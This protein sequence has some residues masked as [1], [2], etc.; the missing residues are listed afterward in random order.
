MFPNPQDALPIPRDPNLE[1]YRKLAKELLRAAKS[2]DPEAIRT[3]STNWVKR[4]VERS[5]IEI[6][7]QLPVRTDHWIRE[8]SNF[9]QAKLLQDSKLSDAQF[10][11][12]RSHGF[13]NW[14]KFVKHLQDAN[15]A[16]SPE[17]QFEAAADAII[18]GDIATLRRLLRDHPRLVHRRSTRE[19][20]ATLLHYVSANGVEG[21]RQKTPKN[22]VEI[23]ELLLGAGADIN[24]GARVY[25]GNCTALGLAAT[26]VHPQQAGV[27]RPLMQLLLD[28][29][30][31][32]D[33][34]GLAG[35]GH[36]LMLA[37]L[38]NGQP[39]AARFLAEHGAPLDLETAAVV[40]KL[41]VVKQ[42]FE[43]DGNL[44]PPATRRELQNGF[45]WACMYGSEDVAIFLLDLGAD[46]QD[47]S[48]TGAT[49][50]HWAAGAG[51]LNLIKLFIRR[52]AL[53]EVVNRW[54]GTVLEHA[55]HG[56]EHGPASVNFA[57]TFETL[58]EAGA[59]IQG[60]WL[61]W[62]EKLKGR[63]AEEKAQ[64]AE[65]FRRYGATA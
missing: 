47:P 6:P 22:I 33:Q 45:L 37:C 63:S 24:A 29:G 36:S 40:G 19:H 62:L 18:S 59:K 28:H 15:H 34:P 31:S 13:P 3:W 44:K 8:V 64:V 17:A 49:A 10:V 43:A 50:L 61:A 56:L 48:D 5:G 23:T 21:Y 42:F 32:I 57:P 58:L 52:G 25:H 12:A 26:S 27:Q 41:E 1:Q 7:P 2:A 9:A 14:P 20:S 39:D 51:C 38:A 55:G 53:L 16:D 30:A 35:G 60:S 11:I 54:G 4:L 65:V 46:L